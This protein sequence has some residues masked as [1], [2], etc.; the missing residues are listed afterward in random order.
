MAARKGCSTHMSARQGPL[1]T[2]TAALLFGAALGSAVAVAAADPVEVTSISEE[3]GRAAFREPI[4]E[5]AGDPLEQ[6]YQ[7]QLL[8]QEVQ[9]LRGI[10]E[11]L[12]EQLRQLSERQAIRYQDVDRRLEDLR[13]MLNEVATAGRPVAAPPGAEVAPTRPTAG[14]EARDEKGL[15][16]AALELIRNRQWNAAIVQL[17]ELIAAYPTGDYAPNAYYWLGEVYAALPEPDYEKARQALAQVISFFPDHRK[18]PDA[19]FKLGKVYHLMGDC[20]R[21]VE[22]LNQVI[23]QYQ[24]KAVA[25]LAGSYLEDKV[26]CAR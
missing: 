7:Q 9:E 14:A 2:V 17:Q 20:E 11:E 21:A 8:Q 13:L 19:A 16:D 5:D 1:L 25:N 24:N 22:L 18:V 6:V 23:D 4:V 26:E 15:Y 10:V 12:G 3:P